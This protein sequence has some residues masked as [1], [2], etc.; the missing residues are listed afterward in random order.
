MAERVFFMI[1]LFDGE[2]C[3]KI[4]LENKNQYVALAAK[5]LSADFGRVSTSGR[6]AQILEKAEQGCIVI[7]E[8]TLST[9]RP[10]V[11]EGFSIYTENGNIYIK[12]DGYLG[13][14]WGIY[15]FSE[16]FLGVDPCYLFNDL[17]IQK[18]DSLEIDEISISD[19]PSGY[20]FR[21]VF[22][23]DEDLLTGWIKSG[24][25]RIMDYPYYHE[26][27]APEAMEK[28]VETVL[29]L[30]LNLIIPAS[31][32]NADNPPEK[33]LA[34][35]CAK[36]G[37]YVS[38]HHIEPVGVSGFTFKNY[39]EKFGKTGEFSYIK[40][41]EL[42]EEMWSYYADIWAKYPNVVWQIG[43]RGLADRPIWEEDTKPDDDKLKEY[44]RFISDAYSKEKEI[45]MKATDGKAQ[46]FTST[47]WMEGSLL[48]QKDAVEFPEDVTV[49][50]ADNGP[51]QMYGPDFHSVPRKKDMTYGIYYHVQYWDYGPHMA[52]MTGIDKLYYNLKMAYDKGDNTYCILN[53][54]SFREFTFELSAYGSMMWNMGD[55]KKPE[56]LEKY[57]KAFGEYKDEV[58]SAV[59]KYYDYSAVLPNTSLPKHHG[60]YFN[61]NIE[62][63]ADGVKNCVI[64][65]CFTLRHGNML[66]SGMKN[67]LDGDVHDEMYEAVKGAVPKY[68]RLFNELDGLVKK[69]PEKAAL[70]V[71]VKW[72]NYCNI[73]LCLYLWYE[74]L[75]LA[76][77]AYDKDDKQE[78][79]AKVKTAIESLERLVEFRKCAEYG[80]FQNWYR[81]DDKM[82]I[83]KALEKTK[84]LLKTQ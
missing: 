50:F 16:K 42:M 28:I 51:N 74:A 41:P 29:R 1:K 7:C 11:D 75:Y 36:R 83:K 68:E 78:Y 39:C 82:T 3:I 31:F 30:K 55:F 63:V 32:L 25:Y 34:D 45:I 6:K 10:V 84:G 69:L 38:Q 53:S 49:I 80:V 61:Y 19:K 62:E 47:L 73:M 46:Y 9:S 57:G 4:A 79:T 27:V 77:K 60:K 58:L 21:G 24:T 71:R 66:V 52:P 59:E 54:S 14:M 76:K 18:R 26:V 67:P 33:T 20:G 65:D 48:A 64:K 72:Q 17:E 44:G 22:I 13:T 2:S 40:N 8:N 15:T 43:L 37:I 35:V 5:D 12:A 23:N 70:H 81:G 56:Q